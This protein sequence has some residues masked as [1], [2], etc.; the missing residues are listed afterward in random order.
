MNKWF[1]SFVLIVLIVLRSKWDIYVNL[2][3]ALEYF[4]Y[5]LQ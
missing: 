4:D 2:L 1:N 5:T 3:Y